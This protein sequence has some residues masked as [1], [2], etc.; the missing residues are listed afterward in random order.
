MSSP[1]FSTR[2]VCTISPRGELWG[3]ASLRD[4]ARHPRLGQP[5][6]RPHHR[7]PALGGQRGWRGRLPGPRRPPHREGARSPGHPCDGP[8]SPCQG[9][10]SVWAQVRVPPASGASNGNSAE[11][12]EDTQPQGHYVF[13]EHAALQI[14][15]SPALS[16]HNIHTAHYWF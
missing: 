3:H 10:K 6:G 5:S 13:P 15:V 16:H 11:E 9:F 14:N 1:F 8:A 7:S 4:E 12:N 2:H